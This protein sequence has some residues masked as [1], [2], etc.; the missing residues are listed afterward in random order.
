M[1]NPMTKQRDIY[2]QLIHIKILKEIIIMLLK[3]KLK[4]LLCIK[5]TIFK[6]GFKRCLMC[7]YK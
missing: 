7:K 3:I 5:K 1:L 6:S 2:I 4:E